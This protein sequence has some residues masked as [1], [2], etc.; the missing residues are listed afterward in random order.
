YTPFSRRGLIFGLKFVVA[1]GIS[2]LGVL[3]EGFMFDL[4]GGF[5]WLFV[6]LGGLAAI[7]AV[8]ALLLPSESISAIPQP[9]E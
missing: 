5:F 7:G 6:V 9:A 2:S 1:I 8:A 4:T 3:L